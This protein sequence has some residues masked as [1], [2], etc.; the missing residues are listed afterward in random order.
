MPH[1]TAQMYMF[2][3]L[4]TLDDFLKR[5]EIYVQELVE[6]SCEIFKLIVSFK[7]NSFFHTR[8]C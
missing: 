1:A 4:V 8:S 6:R 5:F 2:L 3:G 7:L